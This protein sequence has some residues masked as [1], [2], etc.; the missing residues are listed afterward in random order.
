MVYT[1]PKGDF[2]AGVGGGGGEGVHISKVSCL[3][4][5]PL[6]N[7]ATNVYACSHQPYACRLASRAA[8]PSIDQLGITLYVCTIHVYTVV[9]LCVL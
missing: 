6:N 3:L 7:C 8:R 2:T 4:S 9:M 5:T 1:K